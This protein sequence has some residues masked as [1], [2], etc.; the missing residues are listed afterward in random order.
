MKTTKNNEE[1]AYQSPLQILAE[2]KSNVKRIFDFIDYKFSA[3]YCVTRRGVYAEWREPAEIIFDAV[4]KFGE[5]FVT[6]ICQ[7]AKNGLFNLSDK[8]RWCVA[9]AFQKLSEE[10]I[11]N[12]YADI[13]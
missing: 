6:D 12:M 4:L 5:G 13:Q 2:S 10:Q 11:L 8:Q 7:R 9:F 1:R 3:D